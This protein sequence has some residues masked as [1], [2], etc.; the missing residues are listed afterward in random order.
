MEQQLNGELNPWCIDHAVSFG[1]YRGYLNEHGYACMSGSAP[2]SSNNHPIPQYDIVQHQKATQ[3][4]VKLSY[5]FNIG[6]D[7]R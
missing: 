4:N 7:T 6:V 3:G 2:M 1:R 5:V